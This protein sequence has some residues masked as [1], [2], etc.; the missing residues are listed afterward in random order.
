MLCVLIEKNPEQRE[1]SL[2][3]EREGREKYRG[4]ERRTPVPFSCEKDELGQR[5]GGGGDKKCDGKRRDSWS[6]GGEWGQKGRKTYGS[7]FPHT[8]LLLPF[9][10]PLR[11]QMTVADEVATPNSKLLLCPKA[12]PICC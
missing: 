2:V 3:K 4:L 6:G 10:M 7:H 5:V 12:L 9:I 1:R 11:G 8:G